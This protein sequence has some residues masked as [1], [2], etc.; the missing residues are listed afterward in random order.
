MTVS[1]FKRGQNIRVT[2]VAYKSEMSS[3]KNNSFLN[4]LTKL[5]SNLLYHA[6]QLKKQKKLQDCWTWDG[7]VLIK[8]N[9]AK[10]IPVRCLADLQR[11]AN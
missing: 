9:V 6:R 5:R 7:V 1:K 8:N 4:H 10:I 2:T 11:I 3:L